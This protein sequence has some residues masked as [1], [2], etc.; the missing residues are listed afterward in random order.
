MSN[1]WTDAE[2]NVVSYLCTQLG[3]TLNTEG[4]AGEF[5]ASFADES[6]DYMWFFAITGGGTPDD[7]GAGVPYCGMNANAVFEGIF[8][9]REK[10]QEYG[11]AVKNL[12][13]V[14]T[15]TITNIQDLRLANEPEIVRG[16]VRRDPDQ[17][18]AGNVRIWHLIIQLDCIVIEA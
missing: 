10:A 2:N 18:E 17:V 4:F 1:S 12:L 14:A 6:L 8:E 16:E 5:P 9:S 15:G 7:V 13:P 3:D 11:I